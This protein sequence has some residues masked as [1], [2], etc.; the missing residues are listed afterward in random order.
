MGSSVSVGS[1]SAERLALFSEEKKMP[2]FITEV[3]REKSISGSVALSLSQFDV[4]RMTKSETEAG[5]L[6]QRVAEIHRKARAQAFDPVNSVVEYQHTSNFKKER[7]KLGDEPPSPD[8]FHLP[9]YLWNNEFFVGRDD[10]LRQIQQSMFSR[11]DRLNMFAVTGF[12]GIGKSSLVGTYAEEAYFSYR[13]Y[14]YV[15][16][17][18]AD[19]QESLRDSYINMALQQMK[20]VSARD[21]KDL[22]QI[23]KYVRKWFMQEKKW[24][25]V[26]DNL[27]SDACFQILVNCMIGTE[28]EGSGKPFLPPEQSSGHVLFTSRRSH[29]S[30]FEQEKFV[31]NIILE[32][33]PIG[34]SCK[35]LLM[36]SSDEENRITSL[37][38]DDALVDVEES[39]PKEYGAMYS[40]CSEDGLNGLPLALEQAAVYIRNKKVKFSAYLAEFKKYFSKCMAESDADEGQQTIQT[41]YDMNLQRLSPNELEVLLLMSLLRPERITE[42]LLASLAP[43]IIDTEDREEKGKRTL[44]PWDKLKEKEREKYNLLISGLTR[45]SLIAV[46]TEL[47]LQGTIASMHR[48]LQLVLLE[49]YSEYNSQMTVVVIERLSRLFGFKE[50]QLQRLQSSAITQTTTC[51]PHIKCA[52]EHAETSTEQPLSVETLTRIARLL[53]KS[54]CILNA[55]Q[56]DYKNALVLHYRSLT[57]KCEKIFRNVL[58]LARP[59]PRGDSHEDA[60]KKQVKNAKSS[61]DTRIALV[62]YS[63]KLESDAKNKFLQKMKAY[64][65]Q[66][67][68]CPNHVDVAITLSCIGDAILNQGDCS[69]ALLFYWD[70]LQMQLF[71]QNSKAKCDVTEVA[72][73]HTNVGSALIAAGFASSAINFFQETLELYK[74]EFG[75]E[76]IHEDIASVLS[77]KAAAHGTLGGAGN[78]MEAIEC[79]TKSLAIQYK[80]ND[81][82]RQ[83]VHPTLAKTLH[84]LG[85]AHLENREWTHA[86]HYLHKSLAMKHTIYGKKSSH[87][88]ISITMTEL[89]SLYGH[90][91]DWKMAKSYTLNALMMNLNIHGDQHKSM[92]QVYLY[93]ALGDCGF[94]LHEYEQA[95]S[96]YLAAVNVERNLTNAAYNSHIAYV[97]RKLADYGYINCN[98][99]YKAIDLAREVLDWE[100][101]A[102]SDKD[103]VRVINYPCTIEVLDCLKMLVRAFNKASNFNAS[104]EYINHALR[105]ERKLFPKLSDKDTYHECQI[106]TMEVLGDVVVGN[107]DLKKG[108]TLYSHAL[109]EKI[110]N[111][112]KI[113][114]GEDDGPQLPYCRNYQW[115]RSSYVDKVGGITDE[116]CRQILGKLGWIA[117]TMQDYKKCIEFYEHSLKMAIT[118]KTHDVVE[119]LLSKLLAVTTQIEDHS[120]SVYYSKITLKFYLLMQGKGGGK[121][122]SLLSQE[123]DDFFPSNR[124]STDFDNPK[125]ADM[126][127]LVGE[128]LMKVNEREEAYEYFCKATSMDKRLHRDGKQEKSEMVKKLDR[129]S[130]FYET[131]GD[132]DSAIDTAWEAQVLDTASKSRIEYMPKGVLTRKDVAKLLLQYG[133]REAQYRCQLTMGLTTTASKHHKVKG[134]RKNVT[135]H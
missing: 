111:I 4:K 101:H 133:D 72:R 107:G 2:S 34:A 127:M 74:K 55:T 29:H 77:N 89:G 93:E 118:L 48:I 84:N 38:V 122:E 134:K 6:W 11:K 123:G 17:M 79:L 65:S 12:G 36:R 41:T 37:N 30:F 24:L 7:Q 81:K 25:L 69:N 50:I 98:E 94:K 31:G 124:T 86:R 53:D 21:E 20:I 49:K 128:C 108:T 23:V 47:T 80:L 3:I 10:R 83:S 59:K 60:Y 75:A 68:M 125:I 126:L 95:A 113:P 44:R 1:L 71:E 42:Q 27:D 67:K 51:L 70:A 129:V 73:A 92:Q 66:L 130:Q 35:L 14:D 135:F 16:F 78:K 112:S 88:S 100:V 18:N 119:R 87:P 115:I 132:A 131:V 33:L 39:S 9:Y 28:M 13:K 58:P 63:N 76:F 96:N 90:L 46:G 114:G 99:P 104:T 54:G 116:R 62:Q 97:S 91:Y 8:A 82:G 19:T 57:I 120:A 43:S 5:L 61:I 45:Y 106:D 22:I 15:L 121:F 32:N 56:A 64:E 85:I 40:I 110:K 102:C 117:E 26:I 105:I 109:Q 52:I 103:V